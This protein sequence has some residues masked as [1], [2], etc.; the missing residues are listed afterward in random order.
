[1]SRREDLARAQRDQTAAKYG[2]PTSGEDKNA[3]F[4]DHVR[5]NLRFFAAI[6]A[7]T[8]GSGQAQ[9][10]VS[11]MLAGSEMLAGLDHAATVELFTLIAEIR[12]D[13]EGKG[14]DGVVAEALQ[15]RLQDLVCRFVIAEQAH[16]A[17]GRTS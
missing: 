4:Q 9:P 2:L 16:D 12:R 8:F 15:A 6:T 13:M 10:V 17:K 1:M 7:T 11:M 5:E 3:A 14:A